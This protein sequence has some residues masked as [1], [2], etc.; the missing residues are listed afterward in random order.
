MA[1]IEPVPDWE[2]E[3][4]HR[5]AENVCPVCESDDVADVTTPVDLMPL[6]LCANGHIA[7]L[8]RRE[9]HMAK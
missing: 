4:K 7:V 8:K 9:A 6:G 1:S 3:D 5:P 2:P